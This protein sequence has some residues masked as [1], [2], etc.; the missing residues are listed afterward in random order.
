V[1]IHFLKPTDADPDGYDEQRGCLW[2][3]RIPVAAT[4]RVVM[5]GGADLVVRSNNDVVVPNSTLQE[6]TGGGDDIRVF[7]LLARSEGYSMLEASDAR[8][9]L[10][11]FIQI[12]GVGAQVACGVANSAKPQAERADHG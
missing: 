4:R 7:S 12:V 11:A 10:R 3:V 2:R 1:A 8:G 6:Q 5:T 9:A